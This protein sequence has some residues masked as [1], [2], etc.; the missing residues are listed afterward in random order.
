MTRSFGVFFDLRP[1]EQLSKQSWGWWF[2]TPSR[3]LWRQCNY[4]PFSRVRDINVFWLWVLLYVYRSSYV[5]YSVEES[6]DNN[7]LWSMWSKVQSI[8]I[9][10][11]RHPPIEW[12]HPVSA[13][14]SPHSWWKSMS[15]SL[16][17]HWEYAKD[18][19]RPPNKV[20]WSTIIFVQSQ[21][22]FFSREYGAPFVSEVRGSRPWRT[23]ETNGTDSWRRLFR[24][25]VDGCPWRATGI[26]FWNKQRKLLVPIVSKV[27]QSRP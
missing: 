6:A 17:A 20:L 9:W 18:L 13:T 2:G 26:N 16:R 3:S 10:V 22:A 12:N 8:M 1:N 4:R 24:K 7:D 21:S 5:Q 25:S 19:W 11:L 14:V 27:C 23:F 15:I